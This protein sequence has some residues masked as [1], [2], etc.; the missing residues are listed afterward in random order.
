MH[1]LSLVDGNFLSSR[2]VSHQIL[3][4]FV[5]LTFVFGMGTSGSSQLSSPSLQIVQHNHIYIFTTIR[6][7]ISLSSYPV[8]KPSTY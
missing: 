4:A 1:R 5:S 3:S 6:I 8:I 7:R 2:A